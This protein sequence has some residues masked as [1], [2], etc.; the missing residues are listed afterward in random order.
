MSKCPNYLDKGENIISYKDTPSFIVPYKGRS[1][2][3]K[4]TGNSKGKYLTPADKIN[5][6]KKEIARGTNSINELRKANQY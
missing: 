4:S 2:T 1:W 5:N 3:D 6:A